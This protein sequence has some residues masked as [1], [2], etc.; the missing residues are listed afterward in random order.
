MIEIKKSFKIKNSPPEALAY[1]AYRLPV[2]RQG[3]Q[4]VGRPALLWRRSFSR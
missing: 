2:G 1:P 3:R 4:A